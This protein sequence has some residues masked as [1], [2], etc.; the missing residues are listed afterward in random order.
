MVLPGQAERREC[1]ADIIEDILLI[2]EA[3]DRKA[4]EETAEKKERIQTA[5]S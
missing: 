1:P 3:L 5:L 4:A 2:L